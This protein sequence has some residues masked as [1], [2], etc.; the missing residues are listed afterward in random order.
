M[1]RFKPRSS[2]VRAYRSAKCANVAKFIRL[3][4]N[5]EKISL[6][7]IVRRIANSSN[8][9]QVIGLFNGQHKK[10]FSFSQI[11]MEVTMLSNFTLE[12]IKPTFRKSPLC[13]LLLS[14]SLLGKCTTKNSYL[15]WSVVV[16]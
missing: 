10:V 11:K 5:A 16:A 8:R 9:S 12:G 13:P 3:N 2:S 4:R 1:A 7:F 14:T 6:S 15:C